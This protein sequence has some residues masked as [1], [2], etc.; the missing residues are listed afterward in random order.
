MI[1]DYTKNEN[2]YDPYNRHD[3]KNGMV[4]TIHLNNQAMRQKASEFKPGDVFLFKVKMKI[5]GGGKV[6]GYLSSASPFVR[7]TEGSSAMESL[8]ALRRCA[9][10]ISRDTCSPWADVRQSSQVKVLLRRLATRTSRSGAY[11]F[12]EKSSVISIKQ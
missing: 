7:V 5:I 8:V 9:S 4:L 3:G 2:L 6:R 11:H 12:D 10:N 1:C